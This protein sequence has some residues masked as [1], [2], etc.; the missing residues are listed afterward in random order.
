MVL[1]IR[2]QI[3]FMSSAESVKPYLEL[4][5]AVLH[6]ARSEAFVKRETMQL[7]LWL[8]YK[9]LELDYRCDEGYLALSFLFCLMRD[10][11]KGFQILLHADRLIPK[12]PRIIAM[13]NQLR[14]AL[15]HPQPL[16]QSISTIPS[17]DLP[18]P[19]SLKD[20]GQLMTLFESNLPAP[21]QLQERYQSLKPVLNAL[22]LRLKQESK[23]HEP[24]S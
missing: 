24:A 18:P 21:V 16:P 15:D 10:L 4:L 11:N 22:A 20:L 7:A 5:R 1:K 8:V 19:A 3:E 13:L 17:K 12:Q 6:Q 23:P 9:I 14:F 2:C